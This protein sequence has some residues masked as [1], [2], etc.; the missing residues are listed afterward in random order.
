MT[1]PAEP[2]TMTQ[3]AE[4]LT[5]PQPAEPFTSPRP[6]EPLTTTRPA[7]PLTSPR[8]AEPFTSPRPAEPLTTTRLAEPLTSP[9]PAEPLTTTRP[10]EPLTSPRP[11][12]PSTTT[13][14]KPESALKEDYVRNIFAFAFALGAT[15][16]FVTYYYCNVLFFALQDTKQV[17]YFIKIL[18]LKQFRAS[19]QE[20]WDAIQLNLLH[21]RIQVKMI[22]PII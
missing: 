2:L 4:P 16:S 19:S 11:A 6:A 21:H 12:E 13:R 20:S 9:R 17:K 10:A 18:Q 22:K 14:P 15:Y 7:E 8:P 3:P 1:R 5:S